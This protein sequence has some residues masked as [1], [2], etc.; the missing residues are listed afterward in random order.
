MM[1]GAELVASI[2]IGQVN[3]GEEAAVVVVEAA[4]LVWLLDGHMF[5]V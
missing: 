5:L 4:R 2:Y 3:D 1:G